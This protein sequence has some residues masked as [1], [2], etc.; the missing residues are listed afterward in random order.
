MVTDSRRRATVLFLMISAALGAILLYSVATTPVDPAFYRYWKI[1][2]SAPARLDDGRISLPQGQRVTVGRSAL[3]FKGRVGDHLHL[4]HYLLD[5]NP[6]YAYP[7]RISLSS[8]EA[9]FNIGRQRFRLLTVEAD[10]IRIQ[11][12]ADGSD[13]R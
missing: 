13:G 1:T 6:R 3:L 8:A 10:Q 4:D 5:F 11:P 12:I 9:G 7:Y 2:E